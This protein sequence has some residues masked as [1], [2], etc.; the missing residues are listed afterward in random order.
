MQGNNRKATD[1]YI[2][3]LLKTIDKD[4]K[5]LGYEFG[6]WTT[7]RLAV[8]LEEITAIDLGSSQ[9]RRIL[10]KKSTFT[11]GRSTA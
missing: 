3:I 4:P 11:F 6:R 1:K 2:E 8:Y 5:E 9:V 10:E 7:R